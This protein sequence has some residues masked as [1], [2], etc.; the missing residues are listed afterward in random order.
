MLSTPN[1]YNVQE[2]KKFKRRARARQE[3]FNAQLKRFAVLSERFRHGTKNDMELHK[4]CFE[5][6][7][8]LCQFEIESESPLFTV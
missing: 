7:C 6:C 4:K 5:A 8:I 1:D 2:V 3:T